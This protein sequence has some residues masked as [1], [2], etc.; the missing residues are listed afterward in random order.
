MP[1]VALAPLWNDVFT[2]GGFFVGVVGFAFTIR[3]VWKTT[4][5]AVAAERAAEET[6]AEV[7]TA[8]RR[9][10][11]GLARRYLAEARSAVEAES[12]VLATTRC[13]DSADMMG[14]MPEQ[15][16]Q[17]AVLADELRKF[18]Q[19]FAEKSKSATRRLALPKWQELLRRTSKLIDE[20]QSPF[21]KL[22]RGQHDPE[23]ST[24]RPDPQVT[25][26][27]GSG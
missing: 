14:Q 15:P 25:R 11:G 1:L 20:L 4:A 5:A 18:A 19:K 9:F 7:R 2:F 27:D 17:S 3:Q 10:V 8:F 22:T 24:P 12:W 6:L 16:T 26:E 21:P 23:E 13:N